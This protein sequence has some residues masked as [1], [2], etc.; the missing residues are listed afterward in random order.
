MVLLQKKLAPVLPAL[1][2]SYGNKWTSGNK[3]KWTFSKSNSPAAT[4]RLP[5]ISVCDYSAKSH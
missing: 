3:N 2:D 4:S 1:Q 5:G